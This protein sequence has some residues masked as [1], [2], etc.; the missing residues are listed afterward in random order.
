MPALPA[1]VA[2]AA[3][4]AAAQDDLRAASCTQ[5]HASGS[6][7]AHPGT[8]EVLDGLV[9][10]RHTVAAPP[11]SA[12]CRARYGPQAC[13]R[14][15]PS[16]RPPSSASIALYC[17][18]PTETPGRTHSVYAAIA[19]SPPPP[20][21]RASLAALQGGQAGAH[22][23]QDMPCPAAS[24]RPHLA[25]I[26]TATSPRIVSDPDRRSHPAT[27]LGMQVPRAYS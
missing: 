6:V 14:I 24:P 11:P 13:R 16:P 3:V 9:P 1:A 21:A 20:T 12:R 23:H 17:G 26:K 5:V 18:M 27:A 4:A 10:A 19:G 2:V 22:R 25:L 7:H 8:T 15:R